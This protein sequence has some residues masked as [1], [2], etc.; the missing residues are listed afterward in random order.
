MEEEEEEQGVD[1][2]PAISVHGLSG[3]HNPQTMQFKGRLCGGLLTFLVDTGSTHNFI[4]REEAH[5][6]GLK[7][8]TA[9]KFNVTVANGA[10]IECAGICYGVLFD[11]Q[12]NTFKDDFYL[13]DLEGCDVILG[14]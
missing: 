7:A 3:L 2:E 1:E 11:I 9:Q 6:L 5:G 14:T 8:D 4:N 10:R 13:L 12:S